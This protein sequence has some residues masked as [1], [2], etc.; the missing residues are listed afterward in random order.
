MR[1]YYS[2]KKKAIDRLITLVLAAAILLGIIVFIKVYFERRFE[3]QH[4]K[5]AV[6]ICVK[7]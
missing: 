2:E 1:K 7:E 3:K 4:S 5:Y 6:E